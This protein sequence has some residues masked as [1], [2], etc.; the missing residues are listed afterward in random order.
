MRNGTRTLH[1]LAAAAA[2]IMLTASTAGA[3]FPRAVRGK[4]G[5]VASANAQ[6][7]AAGIEI[8]THGGNAADAVV[9]TA[10]ALAVVHPQAGNLGGGGFAVIRFKGRTTTLDFR[11]T[12]PAGASHNM[13]LDKNG[14][15][16]SEKSLNGPLAAGVPGSP[17]GLYELQRRY[18]SLPWPA[19]VQPALR[20][21]RDGFVVS[22]RLSS[23]L[24]RES[25][26]LQRYPETAAIWLPDGKP[27]AAGTTM[28]L[29]QLAAL[30]GSY[31]E[32]GPKAIMSGPAAAAVEVISRRYGGVLRAHDLKAYRSIWR[33]PVTFKA[34]GWRVASMG[35]PSSGGIILAETTGILGKVGW[36][37]LPRFGAPR[38]HLLVEAWRRAFADRFGLGDPGFSLARAA[39]LLAP[40]WI[41]DR[42][43][44]ID[45]RK[46]TRS[47][48]VRPW[49][50]GMPHEHRQTTHIA[51]V[52]AFGNVV[53]LTTTLNGAFGCGVVVPGLGYLLN[54]EM[55][56]FTT[57]AGQ[58]NTYGL[59]QG[60]ANSVG[61]GKRMLS[62]MS[63]T[64]L[65]SGNQ[66]L[67]LGA[68]GGSH[69][70]TATLQVILNVIVD[71]DELQAAVDRPRIHNQWLPDRID[72]E[73]DALAPETAGALRRMGHRIE[74]VE[75]LGRV[76]AVVL[77]LDGTV[78]AAAD[79]RGPGAAAVVR[80]WPASE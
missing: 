11:E 52:D 53:S 18:G 5:A 58:P 9:A 46:A 77:N 14:H 29:P 27:P 80:K 17:E 40:S 34:F 54:N 8:L 30:L 67:A 64:V 25:E 20:L 59:I 12:A 41:A 63:P 44:S 60:E 23:D 10:L 42:A 62:S 21:A 68:A 45:P 72:A 43:G 75:S 49:A 78:A 66:V 16:D 28:R 71:G 19:V 4:G 73:L 32:E 6:A 65:W 74:T 1:V 3:A 31:A 57:A 15:A 70:P 24:E 2:A 61:P 47:Q 50:G 26:R 35:L 7:T 55:D 69:I 37:D 38:R 33:E 36:A 22:E 51:V 56:D 79:P 48:E 13:F 76:N 39:D